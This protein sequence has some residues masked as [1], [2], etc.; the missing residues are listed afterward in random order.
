MTQQILDDW[1]KSQAGGQYQHF[2]HNV[3]TYE[4]AIDLTEDLLDMGIL[5][6]PMSP[7]LGPDQYV[8]VELNTLDLPKVSFLFKVA[9]VSGD[10]ASLIWVPRREVDRP[11]LKAYCAGAQAAVRHG[12]KGPSKSVGPSPEWE[13]DVLNRHARLSRINPFEA[14]GLHWTAVGDEPERAFQKLYPHLTEGTDFEAASPELQQMAV[15][16]AKWLHDS[17]EQL[18]TV[19]G[20]LSERAKWGDLHQLAEAIQ[21]LSGQLDEAHRTGDHESI[22]KVG[23]AKEELEKA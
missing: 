15:D 8:V 4:A 2:E 6:L 18:A 20:R 9:R 19:E 12:I 22:L 10:S 11:T 17:R 23:K 21:M 14:L 5:T 13:A 3:P 1:V 16:V 7:P